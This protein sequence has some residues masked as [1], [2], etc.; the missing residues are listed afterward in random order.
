[1]KILTNASSK[2]NLTISFWA[3]LGMTIGRL[4]VN[5]FSG[6]T[7]TVASTLLY[8]VLFYIIF[9]FFRATADTIWPD[10]TP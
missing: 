2:K 9:S 7:I 4:F 6:I 3:A 1:M 5:Y 10:N 8:A